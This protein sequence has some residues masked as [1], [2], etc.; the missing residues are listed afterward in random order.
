MTDPNRCNRCAEADSL[1]EAL[2]DIQRR[3]AEELAHLKRVLAEQIADADADF[4]IKQ[5]QEDS[6]A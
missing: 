6:N 3:Q 2:L 4:E 5:R 1:A